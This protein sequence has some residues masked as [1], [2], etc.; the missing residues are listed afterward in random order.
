MENYAR[1]GE[2]TKERGKY[3]ESGRKIAAKSEKKCK[4]CA[5][6]TREAGKDL[7]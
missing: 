4:E 1:S 2:W 5:D 3:E 6:K 7:A